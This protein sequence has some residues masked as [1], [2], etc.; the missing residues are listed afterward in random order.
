LFDLVKDLMEQGLERRLVRG[1]VDRLL[2]FCE[3]EG[4]GIDLGPPGLAEL[5]TDEGTPQKGDGSSHGEPGGQEPA[6]VRAYGKPKD[7][8][9]IQK[10]VDAQPDDQPPEDST[11]PDHKFPTMDAAYRMQDTRC[12][13]EGDGE[14]LSRI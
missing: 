14:P 5:S 4:L 13:M 12:S 10:Q 8:G 9:P 1:R 3:M 2:D 6:P 7:E 11:G